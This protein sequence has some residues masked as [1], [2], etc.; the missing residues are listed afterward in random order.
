MNRVDLIG[1]IT[2]EIELRYTQNNVESVTFNLAVNRDKNNTDFIKINTYSGTA[3]LISDY[4]NKGDKI[5]IEGSLRVT[6]YQDRNGNKRVDYSVVA[7][8]IEFLESK[9]AETKQVEEET[10]PYETFAANVKTESDFGEQL[11]ITYDDLPF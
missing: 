2:N 4:C 11:G 1:R 6:N 9:K 8:R 5:A 3:K 10:N 7:N